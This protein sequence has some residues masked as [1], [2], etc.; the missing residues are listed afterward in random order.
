MDQK[1]LRT[2]EA[3]CTQEEPP[4]CK[5][6]C[7][8]HVDGRELCKLLAAGKID[9]AWAVLC[10]TMPFPSITA[11]ICNGVCQKDCLREEVGG[12]IELAALER[13]CAENATRT[14]PVRALPAKGKNI[15]VFGAFLPGLAAAWDL[16]KKGFTVILFC[17]DK[18]QGLDS[19]PADLVSNEIIEK[20][21]AQFGKMNIS[22]AEHGDPDP[23]TIMAACDSFDAVFIDPLAYSSSQLGLTDVDP[24]T[25]R[26][27]IDFLFASPDARDKSPIELIAIGRKSALSIERAL[28]NASLTAGRDREEPFETRLF[29]NI[30]KTEEA[31]PVAIPDG[32]YSTDEAREEAKRCLLCECMECVHNCAYLEEF[33]SYPKAYA[34]Q[35]YN[36][37]SIVMG[38][39]QSNT[40]INSCMLCGLCEEVCPE[41]FAMQDLCL[42]ARQDL[43]SK[44][45]MPPSAHEFA[46]RDM[47]FADSSCCAMVKHQPEH[48]A[49]K[50]VFFPGCQLSA[51]APEALA[52]A[53]DHLCKKLKG[54]TGLML[55]CCAAP[56]D[57][58]GQQNMFKEKSKSISKDWESLGKPQII[59]ACPS[60]LE[61]LGKA[62]PDAEIVSLWSVLSKDLDSIP[63]QPIGGQ[64]TLQDPCTA[65]HN[66]DLMNDVRVLLAGKDINF[67]EPELSGR[68]TECCGFGGLLSNA[69]EPLSGKVAERRAAQLSGDGVTYCSMC[70][71]LLAKTGKRCLHLLDLIF[72]SDQ[73]DPAARP[74]PGYSERR[75]NRVRLKENLLENLWKEKSSPRPS[76]EEI[77]VNLTGE[78][79]EMMEKR[80]IML[81]DVQKTLQAAQESGQIMENSETGHKLVYHRPAIVTYWVEFEDGAAGEYL[82]HR[83]WSHRMQIMGGVK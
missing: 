10:K 56:A 51:S 8:L 69:N 27:K 28:Q 78:A 67:N 1:N 70:R 37:A 48:T 50:Q 36:N 71:D 66:Q 11:R 60:C 76:Y 83:V 16:G 45:H 2:W 75:E 73:D 72:P 19:F 39:R 64:F 55:R 26:T 14:P 68:L 31:A 57:W 21:L 6:R 42:E 46:F 62:L 58:S 20:E 44:G 59:A 23:K 81:S 63:V 13:F 7:P 52:K 33:K 65:R 74:A 9:K 35:I 4:K 77:K 25:L 30:S 18:R 41:N 43:V 53:Y 3:R 38:T 24:K 29:T 40:L 15:A 12:A 82:I 80:R 34:R 5:A 49:S 17:K 61:S 32:G 79:S 54:G 47:E 22:F